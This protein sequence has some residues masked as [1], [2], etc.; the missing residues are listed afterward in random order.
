MDPKPDSFRRQPLIRFLA[1]VRPQ[2]KLVVLAALMGVGKFTLPLAFPFAFKYVVDVL[3]ASQ[4]NA[5]RMDRVIDHW[6]IGV[7]HAVGLGAT[8]QSKLA[9][10]SIVMLLI[11]VLQAGV[12]YFRNY[13][14]GIAGNRLIFGLR[15]QLYTHLQRLPHSFFDRHPAGSIVSRVL[16]DVTQAG[17]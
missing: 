1:C 5:D 13:W 2:L 6:C 11:Y 14:A 10:L 16:N 7:A 3:L 12:S 17:G 15:S 4:P 8:T 9:A